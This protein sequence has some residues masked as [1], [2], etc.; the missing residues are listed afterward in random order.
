MKHS[1]PTSW[2]HLI[3]LIGEREIADG[4]NVNVRLVQ[5]WKHRGRVPTAY[6]LALVE[7]CATH[8]VHISAQTADKLDERVTR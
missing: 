6:R 4:L 8:G 5:L 7:V 1:N 2:R 3:E